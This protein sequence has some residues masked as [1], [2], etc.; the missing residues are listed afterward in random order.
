MG[1]GIVLVISVEGLGL[2]IVSKRTVD[3][4][5]SLHLD[6]DEVELLIPLR[7]VVNID[8][9]DEVGQHP[10]HQVPDEAIETLDPLGLELE[11]LEELDGE[12]LDVVLDPMLATVPAK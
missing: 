5:L 7:A 1:P 3:V 4:L 8:T 12:L 2:E 6:L 10:L 9:P 11:S